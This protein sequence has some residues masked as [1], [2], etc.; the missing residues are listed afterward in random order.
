VI[1][2]SF[3]IQHSTTLKKERKPARALERFTTGFTTPGFY[4]AKAALISES[5]EAESHA[6]IA[7]RVFKVLH[8]EKEAIDKSTAAVRLRTRGQR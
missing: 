3:A 8:G 5:I 1:T 7:D 2:W 6:G 4:A